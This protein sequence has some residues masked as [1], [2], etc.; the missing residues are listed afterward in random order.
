MC[1]IAFCNCVKVMMKLPAYPTLD[2]LLDLACRDGVDIRPTLIRVLTDLYVQKSSHSAAEETQYVELTLG[3]LETIDDA[4]RAAVAASL[5]KYP[6][7]PKVILDKLGAAQP[8]APAEPVLAPAP[9][10]ADLAELFFSTGVHGRRQILANLEIEPAA[11]T[12]RPAPASSEVVRR[13]EAAALQH[14]TGE[15]GRILERALGISRTLAERIVRDASGEPV[16][17][18]AKAL[19]MKAAV[20]QRVLLFLNPAI[21]QSVERVH[22]LAM[23]FNA[24]KPEAAETMVSVWRTSDQKTGHAPRRVYEPMHYDDERRGARPQSAPAA[25]RSLT[26]RDGQPTRNRGNGR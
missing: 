10:A 8:A 14:N 19:G 13:L 15:F 24:L 22:D 6:A 16:A 1:V 3:L 25:R 5:A 21:G 9:E 20:L 7:A 4:T 26:G 11:L 2:G 12:H 18:A 17:I 23:L